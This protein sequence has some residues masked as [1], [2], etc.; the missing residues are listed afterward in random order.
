MRV[1]RTLCM[2]ASLVAGVVAVAVT[3]PPQVA[4]ATGRSH[5]S[6]SALYKDALAATKGWSVHYASAGTVSGV[7]ILESGDAGPTAGTQEVLVGQGANTDNAELVVIGNT[8]YMKANARALVDLTGLSDAQATANS[9]KWVQFAT[10]NQAFAQ[11]VVGI[12]S[13]DV[14]QE[15]ELK[16]PYSLGPTKTLNGVAVEAIRGTQHFQGLK[17][18]KAILY[19]RAN[20]THVPVE[21]DTVNA[22]GKDNGVEHTVY[23]Q[24]GEMVR[25]LAPSAA[26]SIG[27]VG[28]T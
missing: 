28:T 9:G 18:M 3:V 14:A 4:G 11:V 10:D 15:L 20:G 16:G 26:V 23:S 12:R 8:T 21:E 27:P 19:I 1:S 13:H 17:A 22:K 6:A 25:P 24:W 7:T 2:G 5:L